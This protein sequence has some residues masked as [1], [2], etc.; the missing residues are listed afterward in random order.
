MIYS[1]NTAPLQECHSFSKDQR[2]KWQ[3]HFWIFIHQNEKVWESCCLKFPNISGVALFFNFEMKCLTKAHWCARPF[4]P[5]W[6]QI[7]FK[8]IGSCRCSEKQR[9]FAQCQDKQLGLPFLSL[10]LSLPLSCVCV[11]IRSTVCKHADTYICL[12]VSLGL[13]LTPWVQR[14]VFFPWGNSVML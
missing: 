9:R 6:L 4:Q 3:E 10:S 2:K 1:K 7:T 14:D 11:C 8:E 5:Q 13:T 12:P